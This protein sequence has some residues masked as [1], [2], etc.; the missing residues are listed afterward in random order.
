[1]ISDETT[2]C[3]I[4]AYAILC[5]ISHAET[6]QLANNKV[7]LDVRHHFSNYYLINFTVRGLS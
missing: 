6:K 3:N 4:I 2:N 1:M 5:F 7:A